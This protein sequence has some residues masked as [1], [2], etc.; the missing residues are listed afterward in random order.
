MLGEQRLLVLHVLMFSTQPICLG[1]PP[2]YSWWGVTCCVQ[3]CSA[4]AALQLLALSLLEAAPELS[5]VM[6]CSTNNRPSL[7]RSAQSGPTLAAGT[8]P[9]LELGC[10]TGGFICFCVAPLAHWLYMAL[11]PTIPT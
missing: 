2:V 1:N 10:A 9:V 4:V 11:P 8:V 6:T 7:L 3:L 5:G